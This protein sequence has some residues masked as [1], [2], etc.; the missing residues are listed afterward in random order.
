MLRAFPV[1]YA[2]EVQPMVEFY[3]ELGF[4]ISLR[5]PEQGEA[6]YVTLVR[7]EAEMA[8]VDAE[9]PARQTSLEMG[10][11]PRFEMFVY[12][13]DLEETVEALRSR[14]APVL[15]EPTDQPWGERTAYVTDPEG[16]PVSLALA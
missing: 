10:T 3:E 14:G 11:D 12:V 2:H 13:D 8:I 5:I 4:S 9:W 7:D 6:G 15:Q 1:V 16:N